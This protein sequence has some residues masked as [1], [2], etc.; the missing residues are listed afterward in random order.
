[1]TNQNHPVLPVGYTERHG[2][3]YKEVATEHTTSDAEGR[4]VPVELVEF[5]LVCPIKLYATDIIPVSVWGLS[6][7]LG[8]GA[9]GYK[10]H[11]IPLPVLGARDTFSDWLNARGIPANPL[12]REKIRS[13]LLDC[14]MWL[15]PREKPSA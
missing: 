11:E 13:Y 7:I 3:I 15:Q 6:C 2:A 8:D 12:M 14:A 9:G 1:M 4:A 10:E 5:D